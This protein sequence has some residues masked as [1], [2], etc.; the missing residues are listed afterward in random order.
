[1]TNSIAKIII[2]EA[3]EINQTNEQASAQ[4]S[5]INAD[6]SSAPAAAETK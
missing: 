5:P 2:H 3:D 6:S 4:S 1:L